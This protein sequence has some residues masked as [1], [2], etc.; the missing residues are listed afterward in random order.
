MYE[1]VTPQPALSLFDAPRYTQPAYLSLCNLIEYG[2]S[3]KLVYFWRV[4]GEAKKYGV[5]S[6]ATV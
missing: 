4:A 5:V 1:P 3:R 6:A 2:K